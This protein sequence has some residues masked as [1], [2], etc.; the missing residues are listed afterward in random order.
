MDSLAR[1]LTWTVL[2]GS[3]HEHA[4]HVAYVDSLM[5]GNLHGQS[6]QIEHMDSLDR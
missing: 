4:C 3:L 1:L 2:S 5:S 6:C